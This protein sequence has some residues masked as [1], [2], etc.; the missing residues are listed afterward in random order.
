VVKSS[1]EYRLLKYLFCVN[2]EM[3]RQGKANF[4]II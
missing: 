2:W 4:R 1:T 3:T